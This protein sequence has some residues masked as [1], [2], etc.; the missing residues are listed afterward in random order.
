STTDVL[1]LKGTNGPIIVR[2]CTVRFETSGTDNTDG[3]DYG[4]PGPGSL[5][6]SCIIHGFPDKGVSIGQRAENSAVINT[7]IYSNFFGVSINSSSNCVVSGSTIFGC[8]AGVN[9][10]VA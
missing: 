8:A 4:D 1:D 5:V 6:E 7:L 3:V 2:R 10:E 9:F